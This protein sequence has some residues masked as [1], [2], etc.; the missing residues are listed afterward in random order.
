MPSGVVDGYELAQRTRG[1]AFD[2]RTDSDVPP[3]H[4]RQNGSANTLGRW[5]TTYQWNPARERVEMVAMVDTATAANLNGQ[6][7]P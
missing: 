5:R 1:T 2:I 4:K 6:T 3:W 7:G